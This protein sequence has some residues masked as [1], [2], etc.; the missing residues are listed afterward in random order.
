VNL[1]SISKVTLGDGIATGEIVSKSEKSAKVRMRI[2]DT[3]S[4][5]V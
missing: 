5:G 4:A 1:A 3:A 2:P